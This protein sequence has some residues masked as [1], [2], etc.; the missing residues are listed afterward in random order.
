MVY[1]MYT[2]T[3]ASVYCVPVRHCIPHH[4]F[5]LFSFYSMRDQQM[6]KIMIGF[7]DCN[8]LSCIENK[9]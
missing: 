3:F 7:D 4:L 2:F 9:F 5:P 1:T 8:F 6:K